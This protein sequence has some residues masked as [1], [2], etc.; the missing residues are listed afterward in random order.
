MNIYNSYDAELLRFPTVHWISFYVKQICLNKFV[1]I[2]QQFF[3]NFVNSKH[4][5][6]KFTFDS[7]IDGTLAFLDVCVNREGNWF[8][9][10]VYRTKTFT[11]QGMI[12]FSNIY[13]QNKSVALFTLL[14]RAF[15]ISF[16]YTVFQEIPFLSRFI[17]KNGVASSFFLNNIVKKP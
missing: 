5:N 13:R 10:S 2:G 14:N 7:E 1:P 12:F 3:V 8:T 17:Q 15:E 4:S 9:T 16:N 11:G 6:I